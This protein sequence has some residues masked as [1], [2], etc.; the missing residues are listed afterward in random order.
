MKKEQIQKLTEHWIADADDDYET[1]IAMYETKRYS[2]SLFVGHLMIEKI[3][4]LRLWIKEQ[5]Q[6]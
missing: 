4:E 5:I 1:M 2:W 6:F 3:K